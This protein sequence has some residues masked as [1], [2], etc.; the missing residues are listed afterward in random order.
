MARTESRLYPNNVIVMMT[1]VEYITGS[2][3]NTTLHYTDGTTETGN[4]QPKI[5]QEGDV[6]FLDIVS[7]I[8]SQRIRA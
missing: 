4:Y 6:N 5:K 1:G 3:K 7:T 8:Q 2:G